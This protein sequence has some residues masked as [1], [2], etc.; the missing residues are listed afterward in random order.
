[1]IGGGS[2]DKTSLHLAISLERVM[3]EEYLPLRCRLNSA[4]HS[5][6]FTEA[7]SGL[8]RM[9]PNDKPF[10]NAAR[11]MPKPADLSGHCEVLVCGLSHES[12]VFV[13]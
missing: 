12:L 13:C 6:L 4:S 8:K 1:M 9:R 10:I 7:C 2:R 5:N 3:G 11:C